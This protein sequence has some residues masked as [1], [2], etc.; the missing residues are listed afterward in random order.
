[1]FV[2]ELEIT[3]EN[4]MKISGELDLPERQG[5]W[6]TIIL[7][8][9]SGPSFRRAQDDH[10]PYGSCGIVLLPGMIV[11]FFN[12]GND[13]IHRICHQTVHRHGIVAFDEVWF[14]ATAMEEID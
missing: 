3:L 5:Q 13:G 10:R 7:F 1:M 6:K 9:G 2:K 8:H 14:P 11:D 4:G 12:P